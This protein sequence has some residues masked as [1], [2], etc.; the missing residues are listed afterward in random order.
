VHRVNHILTLNVADF[1][2]FTGLTAI[3]PHSV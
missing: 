3:H 1:E 2:R